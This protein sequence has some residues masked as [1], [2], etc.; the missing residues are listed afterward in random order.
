MDMSNYWSSLRL[1]RLKSALYI[2]HC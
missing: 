2:G 1:T